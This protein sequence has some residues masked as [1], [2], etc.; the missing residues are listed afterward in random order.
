MSR[1]L[2]RPAMAV[3][4]RRARWVKMVLDAPPVR[5]L[6]L[7]AL[8]SPYLQGGLVKALDLPAAG[9]D[10]AHFGLE[11]S[12]PFA[13]AVIA[14]ELGASG[15][16]LAGL[17]RWLGALALAAFTVAAT[18]MANRFWDLAGPERFAAANGFFEHLGLAGAWIL[19]AWH[20]L[21]HRAGGRGE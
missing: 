1:D 14:L 10:M 6:A 21:A 4:D 18:L 15:L 13:L 16:V 7:L 20:D 5:A 19:V 3:R 11:P 8:A 12:R 17:Y 9:A 2:S